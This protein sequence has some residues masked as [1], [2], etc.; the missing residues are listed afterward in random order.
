MLPTMQFRICFNCISKNVKIKIYKT[1][2]ILLLCVRNLVSHTGKNTDCVCARERESMVQRRIL[3]PK[4]EEVTAG[5]KASRHES[6]ARVHMTF[7]TLY[8]DVCVYKTERCSTAM[9]RNKVL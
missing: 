2:I 8:A 9:F 7:T 4:R 1:V 5:Y 3:G 6:K